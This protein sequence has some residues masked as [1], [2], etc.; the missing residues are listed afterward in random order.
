[1]V[2]KR[3]FTKPG[4]FGLDLNTTL[5]PS[6]PLEAIVEDSS[7][8]VPEDL[9]YLDSCIKSEWEY[10]KVVVEERGF[11]SHLDVYRHLLQTSVSDDSDETFSN[12]LSSL[13]F[14]DWHDYLDLEQSVTPSEKDADDL[15]W[16]HCESIEYLDLE[17]GSYSE[18]YWCE[19]YWRD[20]ED[21]FAASEA[22]ERV[23]ATLEDNLKEI[24]LDDFTYHCDAEFEPGQFGKCVMYLTT[25]DEIHFAIGAL[26]PVLQARTDVESKVARNFFE[27]PLQNLVPLHCDTYNNIPNEQVRC[28]LGGGA[29]IA[30]DRMILVDFESGSFGKMHLGLVTRCLET[31]GLTIEIVDDKHWAK[32]LAE[33]YLKRKLQ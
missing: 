21:P 4:Q 19:D 8:T 17:D 11:S 12:N 31:K 25:D 13:T 7:V 18:D 29:Y 33:D 10:V 2:K 20:I 32:G 23:V 28:K 26:H 3:R 1:M 30:K 16:Q 5:V 6:K 27:W 9:S 14:S 15:F 24:C 22:L